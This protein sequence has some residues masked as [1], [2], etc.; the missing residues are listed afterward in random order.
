MKKSSLVLPLVFIVII[1]LPFLVLN[2]AIPKDQHFAGFLINPIDGYSYLAKMQEGRSGDWLFHLPYSSQPG[3]G[4]FLFVYY[5]FL[6][7]VAGLLH[8][9]NIV[10]FHVARVLNSVFMFIMIVRFVGDHI[11]DGKRTI[12]I[13]V[14]TFGSGLG[15]ILLLFGYTTA[16][17]KIPEI[18]PFLSSITNPHFPLAIGLM[19]AIIRSFYTNFPYRIL[20]VI[21]MSTAMA[22][23]QPFCLLIILSFEI[24]LLIIDF[25]KISR[26]R[27]ILVISVF[28]PAVIYG[29]YLL[30]ITK[31][32]SAIQNWNAQNLTPSPPIWD[33][34]ISLAPMV[35]LAIPG[36]F[37]AYKARAEK[38][39]PLIAWI[40]VSLFLAYT[41]LNLQR[42][43]LVGIYIPAV[44]L[45]LYGL[46]QLLKS[47]QEFLPSLH[48]L[49]IAIVLPS[50]LLLL[51]L[52]SSMVVKLNPNLVIK[53]SVW[54]G[55]QWMDRNIP[56]NKLILAKPEIA[57]LIPAYTGERVIYGHPFET[58]NSEYNRHQVD[59]F[60]KTMDFQ[61]QK[62]Y[63]ELEGVDFVFVDESIT[64]DFSISPLIPNKMIYEE[65]NVS[66]YMV[67]K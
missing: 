64:P 10:I 57:G 52:T 31:N 20:V 12:A 43:M 61:E 40:L 37:F 33:T 28:L 18:Y 49:I 13:L 15:W 11:E 48:R 27:L 45:G 58:I 66:I 42:R 44:I 67:E 60:F 51:F 30:W 39:Y 14:L 55:I 36:I 50:N 17:F 54:Q 4:V 25:R 53:S 22:L 62:N 1:T 16:D 3:E 41:P 2:Y 9:A 46:Q 56:K 32:N 35:L 47:R 65:Q 26:E 7:H 19:L 29:A 5:I 8:G 23:V 21:L 34:A 38:H 59:L 6:G 24:V 63:V